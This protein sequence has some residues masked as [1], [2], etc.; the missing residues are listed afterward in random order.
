[1]IEINKQLS[2]DEN[3]LDWVFSRASGPGGQNV[4]KTATAVQLRFDVASSQSLPVP[5]KQRLQRLA[6]NRLTKDGVLIVEASEHRSQ[7]ANRQA[8]LERLTR[9]IQRASQPPKKRKSTKPS[10]AAK[11]RRL[12]AKRQRSQKKRQ[13]RF[14]PRR[15]W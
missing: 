6:R 2:L 4:N 13:R 8:A 11:R 7:Q 10:K 5:I 3:E 1:M 12:E 15:D 14:D 9:L